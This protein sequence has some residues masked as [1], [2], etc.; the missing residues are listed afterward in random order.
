[1]IEE[2]SEISK[3]RKKQIFQAYLDKQEEL[4]TWH[5]IRDSFDDAHDLK[6]L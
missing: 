5:S 3:E 6:L 2:E 1:M 4:S